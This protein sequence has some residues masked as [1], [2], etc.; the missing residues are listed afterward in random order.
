MASPMETD[1][2]LLDIDV[3]VQ[4]FTNALHSSTESL[5]PRFRM[6]MD[7]EITIHEAAVQI[8]AK[9]AKLFPN[10][11]HLQFVDLRTV[12]SY[13]VDGDDAVGDIF[14]DDLALLAVFNDPNRQAS[15]QNGRQV[16]SS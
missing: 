12:D 4:K 16:Y 9:F 5:G 10:L 15:P 3:H 14:R 2:L 8:E 1:K 11:L 13:L 6:I 7:P